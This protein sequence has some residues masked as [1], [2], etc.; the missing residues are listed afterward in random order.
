MHDCGGMLP[1]CSEGLRRSARPASEQ[2]PQVLTGCNQTVL[3]PLTPQSSPAG[4]FKPVV[5]GSISKTAL[6]QV[7]SALTIGDCSP[8]GRL[9]PRCI[10]F[11][12]FIEPLDAPSPSG[13]GTL[14]AQLAG[15]TYFSSG[16]I[17]PGLLVGTMLP[18]LHPLAGWTGI[19]VRGRIVDK[20]VVAEKFTALTSSVLCRFD[21]SHVRG[22]APALTIQKILHRAVLAVG[23]DCLDL[24][25]A[26]TF[27]LLTQSR[28]LGVFFDDSTSSQLRSDDALSIVN[29]TMLLVGRARDTRTGAGQ[30]GIGIGRVEMR[31]V[32]TPASRLLIQFVLLFPVG[33]AQ[34]GD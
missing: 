20:L 12:L 8:R 29:G 2:N 16:H 14:A 30:L 15:R 7:P 18:S 17:L 6:H 23:D 21:V 24:R 11:C 31:L 5:V 10:H 27:V 19:C 13:F 28:Q 33:S 9:L 26:V 4:C 32:D 1:K 3:D 22:N 25:R 34:S